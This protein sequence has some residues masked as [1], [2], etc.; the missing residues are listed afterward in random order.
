LAAGADTCTDCFAQPVPDCCPPACARCIACCKLPT[1][2]SPVP[3]VAPGEGAT[4]WVGRPAE[5]RPAGSPPRDV[6]HV[7]KLSLL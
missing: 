1:T 2:L 4:D 3:Q 6:F 5:P 7:P